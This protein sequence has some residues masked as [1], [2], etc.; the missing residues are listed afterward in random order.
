MNKD[1]LGKLYRL[2]SEKVGNVER[3][4]EEP[5]S[6]ESIRGR[7]SWTE[8][9]GVRRMLHRL[10]LLPNARPSGANNLRMEE[11][12]A[13]ASAGALTRSRVVNMFNAYGESDG[14]VATCLDEP[15]CAECNL[16]ELCD[17]PARPPTIKQLP[18]DERPRE[19]LLRRGEQA[20][21]DADLLAIVLRTGR[22]GESATA[23]AARLLARY[24]S[25][26]ALQQ[27]TP[28]ELCQ[29][30]GI[31]QAKAAQIAATLAMSRRLAATAFAPG[32]K[33][34]ASRQV[35]E[36]LHPQLCDLNQEKFLCLLLDTKNRLIREQEI[37]SGGLEASTVN[38]RDVFT[39]AIRETASAVIFV[40]NHPSG[41]PTPS[42]EDIALSRR[43]REA[44]ELLGLRVL[45]HVIIGKRR[46]VSF[47][48][49][50]ML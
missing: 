10:G 3:V 33:F 15:R 4:C 19:R 45:D 37:S 11:I 21:S 27:R 13:Q 34:T 23:L 8:S 39:H 46:Y 31:G 20:L 49:E 48:D 40:H 41:D 29:I 42:R 6:P 12:L 9:A 25:L 26:R 50:G 1:D 43:L 16:H 22:R 17:Q 14:S 7:A 24:G 38:P 44:G 35:Y 18:E 30:P 28:A 2:M 5:A 36:H 32:D 47:A